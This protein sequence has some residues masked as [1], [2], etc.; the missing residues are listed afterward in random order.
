MIDKFDVREV[1][2]MFNFVDSL[3]KRVTAID[4]SLTTM[5]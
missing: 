3:Q 2:N 5:Q 1:K 4:G